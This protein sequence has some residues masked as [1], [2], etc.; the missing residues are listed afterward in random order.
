MA[1]YKIVSEWGATLVRNQQKH[2]TIKWCWSTERT[3]EFQSALEA[4]DAAREAKVS[5]VLIEEIEE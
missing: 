1:R 3:E 4:T 2:R 5:K